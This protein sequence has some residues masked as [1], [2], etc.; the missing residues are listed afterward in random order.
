MAGGGGERDM[1]FGIIV[2]IHHFGIKA[3]IAIGHDADAT[4]HHAILVERKAARIGS[5]AQ[6]RALRAD[7]GTADTEPC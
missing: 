4:N 5:E 6:W 2:H 3:I 1:L 7:E